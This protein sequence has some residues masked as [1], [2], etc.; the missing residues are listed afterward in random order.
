MDPDASRSALLPPGTVKVG[1][2]PTPC[3]ALPPMPTWVAPPR[4][5]VVAHRRVLV[6]LAGRLSRTKGPPN[7]PP[8]ARVRRSQ[9]PTAPASPCRRSPRSH[10]P[11][12]RLPP[13]PATRPRLR[14][15]QRLR[16]D[17]ARLRSEAAGAMAPLR[18]T[19]RLLRPLPHRL[20]G[21]LGSVPCRVSRRRVRR[22]RCTNLV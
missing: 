21:S 11:G 12:H 20:A 19:P 18:Q 14:R 13:A 17:P 6:S 16:S 9:P 4:P 5:L 1:T 2:P 8:L 3:Q 7:G 15:H 22:G 10:A